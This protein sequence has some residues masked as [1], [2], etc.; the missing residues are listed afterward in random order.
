VREGL[1]ILSDPARAESPI[2][3]DYEVPNLFEKIV[4]II[5]SYVNYVNRVVWQKT[6]C[7]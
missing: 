2:V 1:R 3:K 7:C 4:R 6:P 5:H